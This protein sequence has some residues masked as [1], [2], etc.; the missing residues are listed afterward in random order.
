ML[1][2]VLS[3]KSRVLFSKRELMQFENI[4]RVVSLKNKTLQL[5]RNHYLFVS[6]EDEPMSYVSH[7]LVC[8][9]EKR[10]GR[11]E[12]MRIVA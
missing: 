1:L 8:G 3:S 12:G 11:R 9:S 4:P 7:V 2:S 5:R 10:D 6:D